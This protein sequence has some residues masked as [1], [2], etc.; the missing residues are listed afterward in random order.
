MVLL[1][2]LSFVLPIIANN[3]IILLSFPFDVN[4]QCIYYNVKQI[5][6]FIYAFDGEN[7][8]QVKKHP[9]WEASIKI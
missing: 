3:L 9:S 6:S 4:L 2:V 1:V 8:L 5:S 7:L